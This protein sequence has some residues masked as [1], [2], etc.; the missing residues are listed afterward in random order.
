M[1]AEKMKNMIVLKN[2]PSN[3]VE[4][5][6]IVL[7]NNKKTKA[8]SKMEKQGEIKQEREK[9]EEHIIKEAEM[10]INNYTSKYE[11]EKKIKSYSARQIEHKYKRLKIISIALGIMTALLIIF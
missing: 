7:K 1:Q 6:I 9:P 2:L 8:L 4:E 5:A 11:D 10:L 3:I